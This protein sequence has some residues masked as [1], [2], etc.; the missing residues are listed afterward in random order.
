MRIPFS[1]LA[2][3]S[4][5]VGAAVAAG[6]AAGPASPGQAEKAVP[7]MAVEFRAVAEDG[8]PV[9]DLKPQDVVLKVGG[10]AR[11]IQ[12][13]ALVHL[14][15]G[16][17]PFVTNTLSEAG[18][19]VLLVLDEDSIAPGREPPV[20]DAVGQL[21][22][23][24]SPRD[25]VGLVKISAVAGNVSSIPRGGIEEVLAGF[26][27]RAG[28]GE[29]TDDVAC[30]TQITLQA[31][32]GLF[33][34]MLP[35]QPTTV[36]V[37]SAGMAAA[38]AQAEQMRASSG[39][40]GE[41]RLRHFQA[42][43]SAALGA[44]ASF[45]VVHLLDGQALAASASTD[46]MA[47]GVESL[48]GAGSGTLLRV[49]GDGQGKM[50]RLAREISAYYQAT[51]EPEAAE[52]DG[53]RRRL[54][55]QVSR[56]GLRVRAQ[57]EI[58]I[59][60]VAAR[61]AP[62]GPS[63]REMMRLPT[64]YRDLPL[65]ASAYP[66]LNAGDKKVKVVVLFEPVEPAA[67]VASAMIGLFDARGKLVAQWTSQGSDLTQTPFRAALVVPPGNYRLRLAA[68]DRS[69]RSGSVEDDVRAA[70]TGAGSLTVSALVLGVSENRAFSPR[71]QFGAEPVAIGYFE[72]YGAARDASVTASL[73]LAPA[74]DAPALVSVPV[75]IERAP[76]GDLR[77]AYG[78][79]PIETL[80]AAD[81]VVRAIVVVDGQPSGRITRILRKAGRD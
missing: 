53:S 40:C 38:S 25:R 14:D 49:A 55:V 80:Q 59:P 8:S 44:R 54:E 52:R 51:F 45:Y 33:E 1:K 63:P 34:D 81:F 11:E 72:I 5:G 42:F 27:S 24:L 70:V 23:G 18:Q 66:S 13:L 79:I 56:A 74:A 67:G 15:G 6:L 48:A 7:A 60:K 41:V 47:A 26:A 50:T 75:T 28:S 29:T 12:S 30:R 73:E 22:A 32:A 17:P 21:L 46:Y 62:K 35:D 69:G 43:A 2:V 3:V 4:I 39:F 78:V 61:P 57:P 76:G 68:I 19:D 9:L 16:P 36:V 65:R 20:R 31:L 37:F 64:A 77:I 10:R 58:R 71:L